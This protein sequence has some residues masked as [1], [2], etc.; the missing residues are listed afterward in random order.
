MSNQR[1]KTIR[2]ACKR[3][4]DYL[5]TQYHPLACPWFCEGHESLELLATLFNIAW[6]AVLLHAFWFVVTLPF[7]VVAHVLDMDPGRLIGGTILAYIA[8]LFFG[9]F[10][11]EVLKLICGWVLPTEPHDKL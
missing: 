8:V 10:A 4:A 9:P 11:W 5:W 2:E 6:F 7:F 3:T 1:P